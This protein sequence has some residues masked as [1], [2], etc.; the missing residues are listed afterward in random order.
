VQ[1]TK[2]NAFHTED[3]NVLQVLADQLAVA[4]ENAKLFAET[5]DLLGKHRLLREIILS[6]SSSSDLENALA[7]VTNGLFAAGIS[8]QVVVWLVNEDQT[9]LAR[10]ASGVD[11]AQRIGDIVQVGEG[12]IGKAAHETRILRLDDQDDPAEKMR[13]ELCI[14]ILFGTELLGVLDLL[15]LKPAAFDANDE[16]ILGAL[17][18]NLGGVITNIRMVSRIRQQV[19]REHQLFEAANNIRRSIDLET[20]LETSTREICK[21]VGARRA[22]V[23]ISAGKTPETQTMLEKAGNND[24]HK[25]TPEEQA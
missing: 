10:A 9:L 12:M 1:S 19:I 4:M 16:E 23:V 8:D 3:I 6:A 11:S 15:S 2:S 14:P 18:S 25:T 7:N 13:A 21:V 24:G 17:G 22:R 20:I 5:Q